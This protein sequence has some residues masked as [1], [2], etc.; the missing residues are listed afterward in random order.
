LPDS[1]EKSSL[2]GSAEKFESL[3]SSDRNHLLHGYPATVNQKSVLARFS[4]VGS[5]IFELAE[6]EE[7]AQK[8]HECSSVFN[9]ALYN[10]LADTQSTDEPET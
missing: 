8:C 3:V 4:S 5:K 10:L 1:L 7:F 2:L 9:H 6:L